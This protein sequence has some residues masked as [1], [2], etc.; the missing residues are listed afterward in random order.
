M[1]KTTLILCLFTLILFAPGEISTAAPINQSTNPQSPTPSPLIARIYFTHTPGLQHL[2]DL[3]IDIWEVDHARGSVL[4]QVTQPQIDALTVAGYWVLIDYAQTEAINAPRPHLP[5]QTSGIPAYVCYRTVGET[6]ADLS[7]LA[8]AHPSIARWIDMGNSWDKAIPS[9]PPGFDLNVLVLTNQAIPGPKPALFVMGAVHAREYVAAETATRFAE[10]LVNAYGVDPEITAIL[11][12]SEVH[13]L[14]QANPDGRVWAEQ[15]YSWRK[16]TDTTS[17]CAFPTYG[18]DLNRN[19]SYKWNSCTGSGCS[20]T[21]PCSIFYRGT[22][23]ASEPETAALQTYLRGLFPDQ[24][25]PADTDAAPADATGILVSL[26]SYGGLVLY[27]WDWSAGAAPNDSQ[28]R[29]LGRKFG[30]YNGH[31]VCRSAACLYAFDGSNTDWAYGDL[32]VAAFTF[33]MGSAFFQSCASFESSILQPNLAALGYAAKAAFHPY[34][35][36]AGPEV[37]GLSLGS[38]TVFQGEKVNLFGIGDGTRY[39][40]H[41]WGLQ[42]SVGVGA[43]RWSVDAPPWAGGAVTPLAPND[44]LFNSP[45]ESLTGQ[46]DTAGWTPGR[47]TIFV[48]AQNAAGN[49]GVPSAIFLNIVAVHDLAVTTSGPTL[50]APAAGRITH[51]L[52]LTNTGGVADR[53]DVTL[54]QSGWPITVA[55]TLGPIAPGHAL[56][57]TVAVQVPVTATVGEMDYTVIALTAQASPQTSRVI[58]LQ[59]LIDTA[60]VRAREIRDERLYLPWLLR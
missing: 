23:P 37:I 24:R 51:T 25:G 59:T 14:A 43:A 57:L 56:T 49:W 17:A 21:D 35:A 6:Y 32:G 19:S 10:Q 39:D 3:G 30:F 47:H 13:I 26:H 22:S 46:I 8:V 12:F 11:D 44:G 5:D 53:Y 58:T 45:T 16:N 20:S 41:G 55:K 29:T 54:V 28:L 2:V 15:G 33:E 27:P 34:T 60:W 38:A 48:Q 7:A 42:P 1:R 31:Q 18:V 52:T 4:A 9:G 36:P 40:S 50:F